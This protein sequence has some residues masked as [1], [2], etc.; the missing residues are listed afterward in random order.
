MDAVKPPRWR[1][2]VLLGCLLCAVPAAAQQAVFTASIAGRVLA[3]ADRSTLPG[4]EVTLLDGSTG[5][6]LATTTTD[7]DGAYRFAAVAA[8][9]YA[10]RAGVPGFPAVTTPPFDVAA[11]PITRDLTLTLTLTD[12]AVATASAAG[13]LTASTSDRVSGQMVDVA[14]VKGDDFA[15]LLPLLPGVV[16]G[17]DG[18]ISTKGGRPA[19]TGLQVG[20]SYVNDP[21]TGDMAFDLP[22]D[23][24][25]TIQVT[26]N[27]Y[28]PEA[29]RFSAGQATI[30]TRAGTDRWRVSA[31]N[32][33]P[34][35]CFRIC[36]G[37]SLGVRSY[38]PRLALG[39]PLV[40]GHLRLAE[41]LQF[42]RQLIR[43][44]SLPDQA[45]DVSATSFY[46]FTRLDLDAGAHAATTSLA[47]YPR[48]VRYS[49]LATFVPEPA[50]VTRKQ[51]GYAVQMTDRWR[52]SPVTLLE[53]TAAYK[54]YDAAVVP[55]GDAPMVLRPSGIEGNAFNEQERRSHTVQWVQSLRTVRQRA[56]D[57]ALKA[58][59]D[60]LHAWFT[61]E[62]RSRPVEIRAS[63]GT[64]RERIRFPA[65]SSLRQASTDVAI[66][67]Q[68]LWRLTDRLLFE[69]GLRFDGSSL[70]GT[71]W[72]PRLGAIVGVLPQGR[73]I[74]RGGIGRFAERTPLLAGAYS[75]VEARAVTT[76][77]DGVARERIYASRTEP[78][79]PA[80]AVVWNVQYDQ[81]LGEH[82]AARI[83]HLRRTARGQ[84][85]I[86][87]ADDAA[88][89]ALVLSSTGRSSYTETEVTVRR[90][91]SATNQ[92]S[93]SYVRSRSLGDL[94]AFDLLFGNL[95]APVIRANE[96]GPTAQDVPHRLVA[97]FASELGP[98]RLAPLFEMRSGFPW[99][100][101][102]DAQ[103]FIGPRNSRRFPRFYSLDLSLNRVVTVRGHRVRVG[104]RG[105]HVLNN[106]AP[107]DVQ[108]N[109]ADPAFGRFFN[110]L[111]P[112]VG[113]TV[114]LVP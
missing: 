6:T 88:G 3:Q 66:Y 52:W 42:H 101:V 41:S 17:T 78:L 80:R 4:A 93:I 23:A 32:F 81:R 31:N 102:D 40:K 1:A 104:A 97:L 45:N 86:N 98:W 18:R 76:F 94:N 7:S 72:S 53:T 29:G 43:I 56:G 109:L 38:D 39:G 21:T 36:D 58:G 95:R 49:N 62:S 14:P 63:D 96:Y 50:T 107:R 73:G 106:A 33:I 13:P 37:E 92:A 26:A 22:V 44:P 20:Q 103:Q 105:N 59:V 51:R 90:S 54:R 111:L 30:E 110:S 47:I 114:E 19:E 65:P 69:G 89:S 48:D 112:R 113:L 75:S 8:G 11:D 10:L 9:R 12:T 71:T 16:R 108:A 5:A 79:S 84:L 60:V 2:F 67:A 24:I 68:D 99:S 34:V 28:A 27:P 91:L 74:L 15:S 85:L 100:A 64:L 55:E 57:H 46:S 25:D 87:P 77:A 82:A 35:P 61:G 83:N 70:S